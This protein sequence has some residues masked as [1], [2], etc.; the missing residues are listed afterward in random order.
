MAAR[1]GRVLHGRLDREGGHGCAGQLCVVRQRVRHLFE[2]GE[3][4]RPRTSLLLERTRR[5]QAVARDGWGRCGAGVQ[6]AIATSGIAGDGGVPGKP[7]GTV[8]F[9]R[10]VNTA[11]ASIRRRASGTF[12][13][14]AKRF[15]ASVQHALQLILDI[16]D[17]GARDAASL[18]RSL[19]R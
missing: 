9:A 11:R 15:A 17:R 12:R 5:Q 7:V 3:D 8:W 10:S 2:R 4:A 13:E 6:V 1:H 14:I 16:P 18:L 19:A